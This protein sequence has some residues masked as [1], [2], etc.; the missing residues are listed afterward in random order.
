M[1]KIRKKHLFGAIEISAIAILT[2]A[3]IIMF[4]GYC[5]LISSSSSESGADSLYADSIFAS[6][7][8]EEKNER[9]ITPSFI[10]LKRDK[11]LAASTPDAK[12]EL[13]R[14]IS[15]FISELFSDVS[16][17]LEFSSQDSAYD[18]IENEISNRGDYI[19]LSFPCDIPA[20]AVCTLMGT[21]SAKEQSHPFSLKELYIFCDE[22]GALSGLCTDKNGNAATLNVRS[23]TSLSF[24]SLERTVN[25]NEGMKEFDFAVSGNK[26]YPVFNGSVANFNIAAYNDTEGNVLEAPVALNG[27]L[28]AFGFDPNNTRFF[29]SGNAVTYVEQFGELSVTD[30]G[31]VLYTRE[32]EGLPLSKLCGKIK[33]SYSFA[34]KISAAYN[35]IA[36]LDKEIYGGYASLSIDGVGYEEGEL[37]L[38]FCYNADG[39]KI[40]DGKNAAELRF[41]NDS[42]AYAKVSAKKYMPLNNVYSDIPQKLLFT[43]YKKELETK[44]TLPYSFLPVY[45][46]SDSEG[47]FVAK[48]AFVYDSE[49]SEGGAFN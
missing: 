32:A 21:E 49:V 29:R 18:H 2:A 3:L 14:E 34:D 24:E 33:D 27:I 30:S 13:L 47:V 19:Y 11:M 35:I 38:T 23:R 42:L 48:Y 4:A 20:S 10:G 5:V 25:E 12:N 41:G 15:P 39:I 16:T 28:S 26:K 31:D 46:V 22:N 40:D 6:F 36:S 44:K 8:G 37:I 45:T 1:D 43:L 17:T 7:D 9:L